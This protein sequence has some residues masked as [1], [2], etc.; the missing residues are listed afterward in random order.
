MHW[1]WNNHKFGSR[2]GIGRVAV[3]SLLY[4]A[5]SAPT[6]IQ[7]EN[8]SPV[9]LHYKHMGNT[10]NFDF[11]CIKSTMLIVISYTCN[12]HESVICEKHKGKYL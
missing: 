1:N 6:Q 3:L 10:G 8:S 2:Y 12:F 7:I 9:T 11:P 4:Y 5:K